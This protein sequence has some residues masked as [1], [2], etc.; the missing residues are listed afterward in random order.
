ME[1]QDYPPILRC[2]HKFPVKK[3]TFWY[4]DL[5]VK[6]QQFIN[7]FPLPL[8]IQWE[9]PLP[10]LTTYRRCGPRRQHDFPIPSI[11]SHEWDRLQDV[12]RVKGLDASRSTMVL[13]QI[14]CGWQGFN[15]IWTSQSIK[16]LRLTQLLSSGFLAGSKLLATQFFGLVW[17]PAILIFGE[18]FNWV[19]FIVVVYL[20]TYSYCNKENKYIY[21]CIPNVWTFVPHFGLLNSPILGG[22]EAIKIVTIR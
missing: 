3:F 21:I 14:S 19:S 9:F 1:N 10:W 7:N 20:S 22:C 16:S 2:I 18:Q 5:A 17:P 13:L 12:L 8:P 15:F 4:S 11:H 6:N